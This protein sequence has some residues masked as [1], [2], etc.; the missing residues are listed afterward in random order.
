M[1]VQHS[2]NS[3]TAGMQCSILCSSVRMKHETQ[4]CV[5]FCISFFERSH[6][7][8]NIWFS[9]DIPGDD[10]ARKKIHYNAEIVPFAVCFDICKITNPDNIRS[11]LVEILLEMIGTSAVF[12]VFVRMKRLLGR[13]LW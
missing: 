9:R 13:H 5:S 6:D 2:K 1:T 7:Q 11:L 10:F 4:W 8:I 12:I 3:I